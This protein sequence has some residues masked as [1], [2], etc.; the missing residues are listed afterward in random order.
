MAFDGITT[1]HIVR[2]LNDKLTGGIISRIIQPEKDELY[3]TVKN[4]KETYQLYMSASASLPLLYLSDRKPA[5]PMTAPNFCMLLR[6]HIQGGHLISVSQPSLERAV[7]FTVSHRSELGDPCTRKLIIEIMG[8][9]SNIILTDDNAVI[10]DSIKRVPASMSSVRE[11]LPGR[12]Y[13]LPETRHKADPLTVSRETLTTAILRKPCRTAEALF[14]S[15]TGLS[16]LMAEEFCYEA[17]L[18]GGLST[19]SLTDEDRERLAD[20]VLRA[21][22]AVRE[23]RFRAFLVYEEGR[24]AEYASLPLRMYDGSQK[25]AFDS[26]SAMLQTYYGRKNKE[27]RMREKSAGLRRQATTALERVI[28]K[29]DIQSRQLADAGKKDTFR[30]YGE[31]L[32]VYGYQ[33]PEG[34]RSAVL[35]NYYTNEDITVPLDPTLSAAANAQHFF[36]RYN[37]LK[38]TEIQT[39]EQLSA[40]LHDRECLESILEALDKAENDADLEAIREELVSKGWA[41]KRSSRDK[42]F[43][44]EKSKPML[45]RSTDGFQIAVGK[46]NIQNDE[47]TF[48]FANGGDWW[49]HAKGQ[50][51]S[52][53]I[54]R[55]EGREVPDRAFEEAASLA[56]YY[57]KGRKAPKVEIDYTLRKNVKK[58]PAGDPGF[59]IY[60]TNY[61]MMAVPNNDHIPREQ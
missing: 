29:A 32:N 60:H 26:P 51:G 25:E 24:A 37:K 49:F 40:A 23:S 21:A 30:L 45:F 44:R 47:L 9:H 22:E 6:K 8:K 10:L 42:G 39:T 7:T 46:N 35:N 34:S 1:A 59:V 27:T 16:P 57:S 12:P 20:V 52:H 11:V 56:A 17:G 48:R 2:E 43:R 3:L 33:I 28:K 31:L 13:F 19:Q 61:S 38:R 5:A 18:D 53:V 36:E 58:T 4:G 55:T 50:P 14:S 15:L 41:K 54:L